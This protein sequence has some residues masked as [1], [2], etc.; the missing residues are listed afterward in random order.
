MRVLF[1]TLPEKTHLYTLAPLAWALRSAGHEVRVASSPGFCATVAANGMTAVGVGDDGN[2]SSA[3]AEHRESQEIEE[4]DWS[5]LDPAKVT[6]EGELSRMQIGV[7]GIAWY[8]EPMIDDLVAFARFWRPDLVIWDPLTYAGPL[9]AR[10]VGAAHARSMCFADVYGAKRRLFTKLL[11]EAAPEESEDPMADWLGGRAAGFG[12]EFSEDL[13]TGQLTI[14][15]LPLSLGA[16]IETPRQPVRFI[17]FNGPAVLP[18]WLQQPQERRRVCVSL[19]T[20]NTERYGGDYVSKAAVLESLADLD[21]EV[22]AALLPAQI[23]ELKGAVPANTRLVSGVPLHTLLPTCS[24]V[25]HHGGFGSATG[26]M[27][28]GVPQLCVTTPSSDQIYRAR[29]VESAGA[30]LLLVHHEAGT[31]RI[32]T[33]VRRLLDE[34]GFAAGAARVRDEAM[35][36]PTPRDIVPEL[37]R[38][39]VEGAR[40]PWATV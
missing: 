16:P 38:L 36:H 18:D 1:A 2:M 5:E 26:A 32:R 14:D 29:A 15:P 10:A 24:A 8:N 4:A 7:M 12:G 19:G 22:I 31:E 6:W 30:G 27:A 25:I 20:A 39:A 11:A 21:A 17:P 9:A 40:A 23:E 13:I 28:A 37:E 33:A 3:M 35:A 34:P